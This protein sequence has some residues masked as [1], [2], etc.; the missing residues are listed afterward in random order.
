M[1]IDLALVFEERIHRRADDLAGGRAR[2]TGE[3]HTALNFQ[4]WIAFRIGCP[5]YT[6]FRTLEPLTTKRKR[7]LN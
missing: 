4:S 2:G 6:P 5:G 1:H 7:L 3:C